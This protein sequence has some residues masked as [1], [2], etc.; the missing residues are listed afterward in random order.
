MRSRAYH[1]R[2]LEWGLV[3]VF[4]LIGATAWADSQFMDHSPQVLDLERLYA[5]AGLVFPTDSFPVSRKTL[6]QYALQ[7]KA[8]VASQTASS[9]VA[10][11]IEVYL[12]ELDYQPGK[13]RMGGTTAATY[14]ALVSTPNAPRM[15][16]SQWL[17]TV[18]PLFDV[19]LY[20]GPDGGA[21]VAIKA[22]IVR[23]YTQY[24]SFIGGQ[25]DAIGNFPTPMSGDPF[26]VSHNDLHDGYLYLPFSWGS[27]TFGRQQMQIG[28]TLD[29]TSLTASERIPFYDA[30]R[31]RVP[32]GNLTMTWMISTLENRASKE[33]G[34]IQT[35][36]T[37]YPPTGYE[38]YDF[39][40]N[41]IIYDI[42]YFEYHFRRLRLGIGAQQVLSRP[43]NMF[44][45]GDFFPVFS[46]HEGNIAVNNMCIIGD[47]SYVP[48]EGLQLYF[49]GGL[50]DVNLNTV[51][52]ADSGVPTVW[53]YEIGARHFGKFREF[54]YRA[55]L[56]WGSTH[57][58]W[59][60]FSWPGDVGENV[61]SRSIYRYQTAFGYT[62][63]AIPLTSAYGP[64]ASWLIAKLKVTSPLGFSGTAKVT[65][66]L[67]T[68]NDNLFSTPYQ[69][70]RALATAAKSSELIAEIIGS[71]KWKNYLSV[72]IDP[73]FILDG[74]TPGFA[75]NLSV[76]AM[77]DWQKVFG[78]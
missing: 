58:L 67:T 12:K 15:D 70:S 50:D 2:I 62:R 75:L 18:D 59:G 24:G 44:N 72:G 8:E 74:G 38:Q 51:G 64:G 32:I 36:L 78:K 47:A 42:H 48:L 52:I 46:W 40:T 1:R 9:D 20:F 73:Q 6:H 66:L 27:L 45:F 49:Q 68:P 29:N 54:P 60:N 43:N 37:T 4:L 61:L 41:L 17:S 25:A 30:L 39:G 26:P 11:R 71:Y 28:P 7:L 53:A 63:E 13:L 31:V 3:A 23:Q 57:Y 16:F 56:E 5:E 19:G 77:F 21:Q 35:I 65:W 69:A 55:S 33:D 22:Q 10:S 76:R 14:Q 34:P